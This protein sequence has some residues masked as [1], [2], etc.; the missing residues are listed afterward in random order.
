VAFLDVLAFSPKEPIRNK[1]VNGKIISEISPNEEKN[2][3]KNNCAFCLN[4]VKHEIICN[5]YF[6][7]SQ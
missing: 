6:N 7:F 4:R 1:N 2:V 3:F 5:Q